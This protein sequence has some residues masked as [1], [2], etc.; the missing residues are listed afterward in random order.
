MGTDNPSE[1]ARIEPIDWSHLV[2]ASRVPGLY[3]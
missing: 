3:R 1:G 2:N